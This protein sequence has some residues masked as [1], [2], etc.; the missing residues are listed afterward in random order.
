[1]KN[2]SSPTQELKSCFCLRLLND[3]NQNIATLNLLTKL[4]TAKTV[5]DVFQDD[6]PE[7]QKEELRRLLLLDDETNQVFLPRW[8]ASVRAFAFHDS[9][10]LE[11]LSYLVRRVFIPQRCLFAGFALRGNRGFYVFRNWFFFA[12]SDDWQTFWENQVRPKLTVKISEPKTMDP[13]FTQ[14][15][16]DCQFFEFRLSPTEVLMRLAWLVVH[17]QNRTCRSLNRG[18]VDADQWNEMQAPP[19]E[20]PPEAKLQAP[21]E[22]LCSAER[23]PNPSFEISSS[24]ELNFGAISNWL[25]NRQ[26]QSLGKEPPPDFPL[27]LYDTRTARGSCT[28]RKRVASTAP[29]ASSFK[30][31]KTTLI[32]AK[33]VEKCC[34]Y[35]NA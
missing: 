17:F 29:N 12:S 25:F 20:E 22:L 32:D 26:V 28:G 10:R 16:R 2:S 1:M 8:T 6:A 15:L 13:L 7:N 3:P 33:T 14:Q 9:A 31:H 11:W 30:K 23:L 24:W 27:C 4:A 21:L 5:S 35:K 18:T 34:V 19:P